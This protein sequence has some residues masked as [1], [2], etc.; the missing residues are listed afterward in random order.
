MNTSGSGPS[1]RRPGL[2]IP[3]RGPSSEED[4]MRGLRACVR[5]AIS[6][7][8]L[9][10]ALVQI[11]LALLANPA[12][13]QIAPYYNSQVVDSVG[14]V[15]RYSS[16]AVDDQTV[17]RIVYYDATRGDLKYAVKRAADWDSSWVLSV[18]DSAGDVGRYASLA[19]DAAGKEH[20]SYYDAAHGDLR[21]AVH[22]G[23]SWQVEVVDSDGDAGRWT[24]LAADRT[25]R[26]HIGYAADGGRVLAYAVTTG[27]GWS[28][29]F[30]AT[31]ADSIRYTAIALDPEDRPAI[32]FADASGLRF[33]RRD[34]TAWTVE[35]V[36]GLAPYEGESRGSMAIR[37]DGCACITYYDAATG[38]TRLTCRTD[39]GW[40][41]QG[42]RWARAG[43]EY[44]SL[45]LSPSGE[46]M[47]SWCRTP[48]PGF[49]ELYVKVGYGFELPLDGPS[50]GSDDAGAYN[51]TAYADDLTPRVSYYDTGRG[52]LK[53]AS[54]WYIGGGVGDARG[55][56]RFDLVGVHP[57]PARA[58]TPLRLAVKIADPAPVAA[59]L[60]DV[61]GR[62]LAT[63][64][65]GEA[66]PGTTTLTWN[67]AVSVAGVCFLRVA[68]GA[69]R[70]AVRRIVWLR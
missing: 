69:D 32:A 55:K 60:Y 41:P 10:V 13:A 2:V 38:E 40:D 54:L 59:S 3:A 11:G 8:V 28:R 64:D 18:V 33:A 31:A 24:S 68:F 65:F 19:V 39:D 70:V 1:F 20:V 7:V 52:N 56:E 6:G 63:R 36:V 21:H 4:A 12:W 23:A 44:S 26:I 48:W 34:G 49:R 17:P 29:E 16:I 51:S 5:A 27:S 47:I 62:V 30:V 45:A 37:P 50:L 58:G 43:G 67:P 14:D 61:S 57:C 15:G 53:Y 25:G 42:G 22:V 9:A 35:T 66:P 46:P